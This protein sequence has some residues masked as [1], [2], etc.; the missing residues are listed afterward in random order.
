MIAVA[1]SSQPECYLGITAELGSAMGYCHRH[2]ADTRLTVRDDSH[3]EQSV[4]LLIVDDNAFDNLVESHMAKRRHWQL[5][6][7]SRQ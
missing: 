5:V 1:T 2:L 7:T 6:G 4:P 3:N